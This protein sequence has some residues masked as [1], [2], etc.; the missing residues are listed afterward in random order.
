MDF[1]IRVLAAER[2]HYSLL[3]FY[4]PLLAAL[5]VAVFTS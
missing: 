2:L 3:E 4:R 1:D 5:D